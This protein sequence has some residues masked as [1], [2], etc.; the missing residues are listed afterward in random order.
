MTLE[1]QI[2]ADIKAAML[3]KEAAKLEALRAVKS[4]ILLLKTSPE[5]LTSESEMKALNKMVKQRKETAEVYTTQNRK[6]LAD[7]ELAQAAVI[8]NYLPKQMSE[9]ELRSEISIII[10]NLGAASPAD[11]GKVMGVASKQ[12]AGKAD[13]KIVSAIVKELLSK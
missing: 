8:E 7:V 12:F 11:L 5:G 1:E 9:D 6:D 2:N 4:A 10:N 13:G 3:A